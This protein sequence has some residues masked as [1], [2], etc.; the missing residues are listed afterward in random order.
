MKDKADGIDSVEWRPA[1]TVLSMARG[2]RTAVSPCGCWTL[3]ELAEK[4]RPTTGNHSK[5]HGHSSLSPVCGSYWRLVAEA[6]FVALPACSAASR[7]GFSLTSCAGSSLCPPR[8]KPPW[9]LPAS[10]AA[11]CSADS[12]DS[13]AESSL[14]ATLFPS[15]VAAGAG[16]VVVEF[17]TAAAIPADPSN[18]PTT[19]ATVTSRTRSRDLFFSDSIVRTFLRVETPAS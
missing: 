11:S 12:P 14:L 8:P 2:A 19:A 9:P 1:A 4:P 5:W 16:V 3:Q 6:G 13:W 7:S 17:V 18:A 10:S 15:V